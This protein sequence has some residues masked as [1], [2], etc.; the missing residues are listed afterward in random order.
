MARPPVVHSRTKV[1]I[2]GRFLTDRCTVTRVGPVSDGH[3]GWTEGE[4]AVATGVPCQVALDRR[5]ERELIIAGRPSS[6]AS[7]L[8]SLSTVAAHWSGGVVDIQASDRLVVVGDAA[9]TYEPT[10]EGGPVTDERI[11][12]VRCTKIE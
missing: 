11:R 1:S 10:G 2:D 12:V 5:M 9:G 3:G 6:E 7:F 4:T 8:I